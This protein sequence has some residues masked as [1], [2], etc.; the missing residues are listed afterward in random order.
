LDQIKW[1]KEYSDVPLAMGVDTQPPGELVYACY[2]TDKVCNFDS[3][4]RRPRMTLRYPSILYFKLESA[5][6]LYY[7]SSSRKKFVRVWLSD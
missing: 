4:D 1:P 5:G 7:W 6:S 2:D 3:Y